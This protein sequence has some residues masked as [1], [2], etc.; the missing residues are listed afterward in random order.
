MREIGQALGS[1]GVVTLK[2]REEGEALPISLPPRFP[3]STAGRRRCDNN[4]S[5]QHG[6]QSPAII[7][8]S[9]SLER[10]SLRDTGGS[11]CRFETQTAAIVAARH[12][13]QRLSLQDT[14]GSDCRSPRLQLGDFAQ[15]HTA[16][17]LKLEARSAQRVSLESAAQRSALSSQRPLPR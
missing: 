1:E 9:R 11:D 3:Q 16:G 5:L 2:G 12:R 14:G 10:L 7:A 17:R 15:G 13:R 4:D 6:S 8:L